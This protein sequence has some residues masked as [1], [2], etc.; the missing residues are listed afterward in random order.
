MNTIEA[1]I[2]TY[3]LSMGLVGLEAS[4][5]STDFPAS[6]VWQQGLVWWWR[7]H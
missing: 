7:V 1:F 2:R 5:Q 4:N 6:I 3:N